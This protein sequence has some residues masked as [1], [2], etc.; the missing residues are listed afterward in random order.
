MIGSI[1]YNMRGGK[2]QGD[3][4]KGSRPRMSLLPKSNEKAALREGNLRLNR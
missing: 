3:S 1:H 2:L 4:E